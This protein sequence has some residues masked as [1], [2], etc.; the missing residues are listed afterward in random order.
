MSGEGIYSAFV[1]GHLAAAKVLRFLDGKDAD[2]YPYEAVIEREIMGDI[3]AGKV[4]RDA[5]HYTPAPCFFMLRRSERLR[6]ML[7][8]LIT[9]ERSYQGYLRS[10]GPLRAVL[11]Y[12]AGR[13]RKA[14][15]KALANRA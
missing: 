8:Q 11:T 3:R 1:S 2:L 4:L 10:L 6:T 9:G 14:R 5:Y 15:E 7:C 13:G 12:W